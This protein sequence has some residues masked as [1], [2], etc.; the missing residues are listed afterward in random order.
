MS[1]TVFAFPYEVEAQLARV[2]VYERDLDM[3]VGCDLRQHIFQWHVV[4]YDGLHGGRRVCL[5]GVGR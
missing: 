5:N 1:E 4:K 2:I 3:V